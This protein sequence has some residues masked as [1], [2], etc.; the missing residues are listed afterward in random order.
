MVKISLYTPMCLSLRGHIGVYN[1]MV[2]AVELKVVRNIGMFCDLT[3][4]KY[5]RLLYSELLF[6]EHRKFVSVL[7]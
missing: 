5:C 7:K 1:D 6:K 2:K 4:E 3:H